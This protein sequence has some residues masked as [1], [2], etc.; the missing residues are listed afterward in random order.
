MV[1]VAVF[2]F[3]CNWEY[4]TS[5]ELVSGL[6]LIAK[7]WCFQGEN[8]EETGYHH[9]QGRLSLIKKKTPAQ[10][11]AVILNKFGRINYIRPTSTAVHQRGVGFYVLK[12][13]TWDRRGRWSDQDAEPEYIAR[14][15]RVEPKPWQQAIIE[16][17]EVYDDRVID[18]LIDPVGGIGKSILGGLARAAGFPGIPS[19]GDAERLIFTVCDVLRA[20]HCRR[21]KL[22][23]LDLP[24][25]SNKT[26]LHA[27]MVAI[28]TI[29]NGWVWDSRYKYKE[30]NFD[31]PRIWIMTNQPL[32]D[33]YM[34]ND[35]WRKWEVEDN[36]LVVYREPGFTTTAG[37]MINLDSWV[38]EFG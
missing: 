11:K 27:F 21:P 5:D 37:E 30:W 10:G 35:R 29:K 4:Y 19:C 17:A 3:R 18:V 34:S 36:E 20:R 2:D 14:Q 24:R 26:R 33:D 8:G 6:K 13:E 31:A 25:A 23:V 1:S 32:C 12:E 22:F 16:S 7:K 15:L 28:E 9:W 38:A